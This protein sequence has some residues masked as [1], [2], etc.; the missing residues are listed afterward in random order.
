MTNCHYVSVQLERIREAVVSAGQ[1]SVGST[2]LEEELQIM[3][4]SVS[5]IRDEVRRRARVP[6]ARAS[7]RPEP[8]AVGTISCWALG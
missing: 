2:G 3:E 8:A 1:S 7:P 4:S 5:K 6:L